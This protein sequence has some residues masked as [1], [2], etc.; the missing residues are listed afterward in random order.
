MNAVYNG[1]VETYLLLSKLSGTVHNVDMKTIVN[2]VYSK[3][4]V[5]SRLILIN[6]INVCV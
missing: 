5:Y 4:T 1:Q 2:D 3:E 6:S